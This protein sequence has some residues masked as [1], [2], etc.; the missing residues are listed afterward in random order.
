MAGKLMLAG[1]GHITGYNGSFNF[2]MP[3]NYFPLCTL[4]NHITKKY[5]FGIVFYSAYINALL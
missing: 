2:P 4:Q 3:G 5:A 1:F